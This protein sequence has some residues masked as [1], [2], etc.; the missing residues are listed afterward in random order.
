MPNCS[1]SHSRIRQVARPRGD[2]IRIAAMAFFGVGIGMNILSQEDIGNCPREY[3]QIQ[4]QTLAIHIFDI[5]RLSLL[6][7]NVVAPADLRKACNARLHTELAPL[8][9]GVKPGLIHLVG[10]GADQAH[11]ALQYVEKLRQF[12]QTGLS[13]E[14]PNGR[15]SRVVRS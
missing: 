2:S 9:F 6:P 11:F 10:S 14:P 4:P 5:E 8:G 12:I 1:L 15:Y 3:Q 13:K 7:W